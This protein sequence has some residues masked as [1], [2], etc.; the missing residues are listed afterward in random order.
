MRSTSIAY[1]GWFGRLQPLSDWAKWP[2]KRAPRWLS[3]DKTTAD[4]LWTFLVDMARADKNTT[5]WVWDP[6]PAPAAARSERTW[7]WRK[8]EGPPVLFHFRWTMDD[9][10]TLS[11]TLLGE[12]ADPQLAQAFATGLI[13]LHLLN[14]YTAAE[15]WRSLLALNSEGTVLGSDAA[16]NVALGVTPPP[17]PAPGVLPEGE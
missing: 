6:P 11:R 8:R 16:L 13:W 1:E 5:M 12:N 10:G 7:T 15:F 17:A 4:E 3:A 9:A 14:D 2:W